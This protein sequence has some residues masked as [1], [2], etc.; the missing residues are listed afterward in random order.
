MADVRH[1]PTDCRVDIA[2]FDDDDD[3]Y[4]D[5]D[6]AKANVISLPEVTCLCCYDVLLDPTTLSC[7]HSFCRHCLAMWVQS[8]RKTM[9]PTCRRIWHG[10]PKVN[11]SFR[12]LVE[13]HFQ[14]DVA[15]R[16]QNIMADPRV[17][18]SL[19]VLQQA[20]RVTRC[21]AAPPPVQ[22]YPWLGPRGFFSGVLITLTFAAVVF[23]VYHWRAGDMK[24]ERLVK[25]PLG[26]WTPD[27]VAMWMEN[28]GTWTSPYRHIFFKEQVNGRLLNALG[29]QDMLKPPYGIENEL[30]RR[31]LLKEVRLVQELG[32]KR[33]QN[34]WEYKA[35]NGGK[36][37]ILLFTMTDSPRLT[38]LYMYFFDYYDSFL[39]FI[40]VSC[41]SAQ[42]NSSGDDLPF[43]NLDS[44]DW[45]QWLSF[46]VQ[47][48]L[49]PYQL[50]YD[51]AWD[52]QDVHYWTSRIIM[53][54]CFT[55]TLREGQILWRLR[56]HIHLRTI[57]TMFFCHVCIIGAFC[58]TGLLFWNVL[59]QF[60]WD[61]LFY[62][63]LYFLPLGSTIM[64][65]CPFIRELCPNL[66]NQQ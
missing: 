45:R 18:R 11:I 60:F 22:W 17:L 16:R 63:A 24:V 57:R 33:P 21:R 8:S 12:D 3:D 31:A 4:S 13:K 58:F 51:F 62:W 44:P 20:E 61:C 55:L 40:H 43:M 27:E 53:W 34:L 35:V 39:P 66:Y 19:Q 32:F 65:L 56:S 14:A 2:G 5:D 7:G 10:F 15:R 52:W 26:A 49:L 64:V 59:H 28:L 37:L 42:K 54:H 48:C 47:F 46:T 38:I 29:E 36:S 25:K 6:D 30:H 50:I 41:P 1:N 9:C 23:L